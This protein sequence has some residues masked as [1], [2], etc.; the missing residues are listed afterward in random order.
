MLF[1]SYVYPWRQ[2][3]AEAL[4][5]A[6]LPRGRSESDIQFLLDVIVG[7]VF[8]RTLVLREPKTSNLLNQLTA[9]ISGGD[10]TA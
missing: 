2:S 9:L 3:A 8:Q 10:G 1:R 5:R 7:T 4:A 6:N